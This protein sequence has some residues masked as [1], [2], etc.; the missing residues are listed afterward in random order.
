MSVDRDLIKALMNSAPETK[1]E[2][3]R[4]LK[5]FFSMGGTISLPTVDSQREELICEDEQTYLSA[6]CDVLQSKGLF[7]ASPDML[8]SGRGY[9]NFKAHKEGGLDKFFARE[10][11]TRTQKLA[12]LKIGIGL[13]I[14]NLQ[15]NRIPP[16]GGNVLM[17][18]HRMPALID[19]EL[20]GYA[21]RGIL[22]AIF[23]ARKT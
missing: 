21:E 14:D 15:Y 2:A 7:F 16:T 4:S 1:S 9:A 13:I 19:R 12:L 10:T 5:A 6:I 20:P 23:R 11:L 18:F 3:Y 8:R 22:S 17:N